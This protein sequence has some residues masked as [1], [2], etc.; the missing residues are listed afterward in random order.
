[1]LRVYGRPL[2]QSSSGGG[3]HRSREGSRVRVI[4]AEN[5]RTEDLRGRRPR[6]RLPIL[7][8]IVPVSDSVCQ[9]PLPCRG[10]VPGIVGGMGCY[11][12]ERGIR[13]LALTKN[14]L[15]TRNRAGRGRPRRFRATNPTPPPAVTFWNPTKNSGLHVDGHPGTAHHVGNRHRQDQ[16]LI[17]R[18]RSG[19][20]DKI[21]LV[22]RRAARGGRG[23]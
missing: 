7:P 1:M 9:W 10:R 23:E 2:V 8:H 21:D 4:W 17:A 12:Q 20:H 3:E 22:E 15:A 19:R 11:R 6:A 16:G 5:L 14:H 18:G 13:A